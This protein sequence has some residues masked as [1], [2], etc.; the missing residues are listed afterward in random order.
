MRLAPIAAVLALLTPL[1]AQAASPDVSGVWR[2]RAHAEVDGQTVAEARP[3]CVFHQEGSRLTGACKG[4]KSE[5]PITGTVD[6]AHVAWDWQAKAFAEGGA[7]GLVSF[8]GDIGA[9]GVMRGSWTGSVLPGLV[10]AFT[11][12]R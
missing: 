11:G 2:V 5:G 1:A 6:G 4:P 7:T 8:K 10:G 9:D 3:D 12:E